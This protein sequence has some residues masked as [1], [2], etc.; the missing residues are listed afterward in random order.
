LYNKRDLMLLLLLLRLI[1]IIH[2]FKKKLIEKN[3]FLKDILSYL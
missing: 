1:C 2:H 3:I